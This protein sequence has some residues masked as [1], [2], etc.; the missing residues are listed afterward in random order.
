MWRLIWVLEKWLYNCVFEKVSSDCLI[1]FDFSCIEARVFNVDKKI[2]NI[3]KE[4][5]FYQICHNCFE[6]FFLFYYIRFFHL[7]WR[8]SII[9]LKSR[10]FL[11]FQNCNSHRIFRDCISKFWSVSVKMYSLSETGLL[12]L[13]YFKADKQCSRQK[14]V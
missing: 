12:N 4:L 11:I 2:G 6:T 8:W 3:K 13:S 5:R 14:L 9:E 10:Y 7:S 1:I